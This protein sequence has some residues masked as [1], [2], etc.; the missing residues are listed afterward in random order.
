M[1][2]NP[3]LPAPI[4]GTTNPNDSKWDGVVL[5][6]E[7]LQWQASEL[8]F[9]KAPI[10][11]AQKLDNA[12][13]NDVLLFPLPGNDSSPFVVHA[14][15]GPVNRDYD[16][17]RRYGEAAAN[18]IKRALKA[19]SKRPLLV[20]PP[21]AHFTEAWSAAVLG[22][23]HALY[24]P[25]EVR[26]GVKGAAQKVEKLGVYL[27]SNNSSSLNFVSA[28]EAGRLVCRDIGGSD[29]ERMAAPKV[30][31]YVRQVFEGSAIKI[32]VT[33]D[34]GTLKKD[35]PLYSAVNRCTKAVPRHQGRII[36]LEYTGDGPI[37]QTLLLVGKGVT[38]DTGGADIKAG[39]I[40][41]GMHRD[42]CGAAAVAGFFQILNVLRP[43]GLHVIGTM[44]MVRNSVGADC[45]VADEII[46]SAAGV[47]V[48]V[49]NT[50]AEGRMAMADALCHAKTAALKKTNPHIFTI[51]TLTGH[52]IRA[53]GPNYSIVMDN[54]PAAEKKSAQEI[55][56]AGA[57]IG[58][59][60]EISTIR[61]ED[62]EFV[63]G[64]NEYED[65]IQCNNAPSS[66]TARGHQFPAAFMIRAAGL[67][68]HGIDS[69]QP[70][71]YSHMDIAG[72]SGPYPGI[73]TAAP[74]VAM[75]TRYVR[76]R[77]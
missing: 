32:N 54:G 27:L 58:D 8:E 43:K 62:Y 28:V 13:G 48:R 37:D 7:N 41:A 57:C 71:P 19:G 11:A 12:V 24:V 70:L 3:R 9:L 17:V 10:L 72:S 76:P 53:M 59:P 36:Q 44:A 25:I 18:G 39:G 34:F 20:V 52:A 55:Q 75:A 30:E 38:Y 64:R 33:S 15:T 26:E 46:T 73:P 56:A 65:V 21:G 51:A 74:I 35:Y 29:P 49:G 2:Q 69:S 4:E 1:D 61:R 16:D 66:G 31:E 5:V 45:Y 60:F 77:L 23:L 63:A 14:P 67:D 50:D 47:R 42:K 22:A 40:M 68:K 6:C